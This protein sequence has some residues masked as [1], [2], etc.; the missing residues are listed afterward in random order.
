MDIVKRGGSQ[1]LN[2]F[3]ALISYSRRGADE[4][5][6]LGF[7]REKVFVAY[8]AVSP[9]PLYPLP[10]RPPAFE[11]APVILF[12]GRL[13]ARKRL[14]DLLR[15]C[16]EMEAKP[17]LIIV[18]DGPERGPLESLAR[19]VYPSVEFVGAKHGAE[20][21]PYFTEADL[22]VLPGDR[23]SRRAGSDEFM[24]CHRRCKR[25]WYPG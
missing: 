7:P 25:G 18:G 4:Y 20:L 10:A 5:A 16:A 8:N 17:R 22:F 6:A 9:R 12:V 23:R 24:A 3:D 15:A 1:F 14:D 2:Q 11:I 19:Q 21:K 13:Q